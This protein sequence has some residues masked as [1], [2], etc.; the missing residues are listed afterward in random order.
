MCNIYINGL[1]QIVIL[2]GREGNQEANMGVLL[3]VV[4]STTLS[5]AS[6]DLWNHTDAVH[7]CLTLLT[8]TF[9]KTPLL[10]TAH[11]NHFAPLFHLGEFTV[12]KGCRY[13][14]HGLN[15]LLHSVYIIVPI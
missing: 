2:F 4:T 12:F 8:A 1:F 13:S 9:K 5:R 14:K 15:I 6:A 11:H 3:R 10:F 7:G